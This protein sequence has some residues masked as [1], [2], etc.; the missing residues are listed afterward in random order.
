LRTGIAD[1]PLHWGSV[2]KWLF[3][4]MVELGRSI[5]EIIVLEFGRDEFLRKMS[6]PLWLQAF[7][8]VLG[9]DF[10]SSGCTSVTLGAL[11]EAKLEEYGIAVL[12]G[13]GRTS[14]KTPAEIENLA[15]TF[16]F[17]TKR[18]KN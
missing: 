16:S 12:G 15:D 2:P 10:H 8:C 9:F 13:K 7:A 3:D 11:K 5:T 18:S 4:R 17:S 14:R 1:L 6:D